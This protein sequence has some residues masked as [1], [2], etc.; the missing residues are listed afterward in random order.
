M[1][2]KFS[3]KLQR[4]VLRI[5]HG[6]DPRI[7]AEIRQREGGSNAHQRVH[8]QLG[9]VKTFAEVSS[10]P[11]CAEHALNM[12]RQTVVRNLKSAGINLR[13]KEAHA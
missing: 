6:L 12:I 8:V 3:T 9:D 11:S 7:K 1:N 10:S 2:R 13:Q 4:E 5:I